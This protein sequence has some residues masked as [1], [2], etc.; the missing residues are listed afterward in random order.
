MAQI[1]TLVSARS[2][3]KKVTLAVLR[4]IVNLHA[5]LVQKADALAAEL[6]NLLNLHPKG[7]GAKASRRLLF[8]EKGIIQYYNE[9][10]K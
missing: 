3:V 4:P 10:Y 1:S 7:G 8:H 2:V 5:S 6:K 9:V